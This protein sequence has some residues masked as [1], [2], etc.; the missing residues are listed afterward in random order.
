MQAQPG[1]Q[2]AAAAV[3]RS[4][5]GQVGRSLPIV[6]GFAAR[7]PASAV[8]DLAGGATIRRLTPDKSV[9]FSMMV[10]AADSTGATSSAG[11]SGGEDQVA[12]NYPKTTGATRVWAQG[13][14]GAGVT[15]AIIDTGVSSVPDLDGRI[16]AGPDFSGEHDS[17][18]DSYGH[19]TVMA[20]VIAGDGTSSANN[21]GGAYVGIA[22]EATVLSVKVAGRNGATDVSTVL[23]AMQ[24]IASHRA[25]HNIRVL[26]LSWGTTSQQSPEVDPINY[27]VQRLWRS[28]IVVVAAAGNAGPHPG[29]VTKPGDD[30]VIITAGA[31]ND[32]QNSVLADDTVT[33]WSSRGPTAAGAAKPDI[34]APGRTLVATR[35]P[36]SD[37][38]QNNPQALVGSSYIRGSGTSQATAAVSGSVAL[39]IGRR[40]DLQP[41][42]VKYAV[43]STAVPIVGSSADGHGRIWLP[44]MVQRDV[45]AAPVQQSTASG[46]GSIEDSRGG[47]H[48]E[49]VCAGDSA[50]TRIQGEIDALCQPWNG[51]TW[52]G[53]TWTG[54]T[55][56]QNTW[57]GDTWSGDTWTGDT[58]S[59]D[60][61]T[62]DT[63]TGTEFLTAFWGNQ[64][65]WWQRLPGEPRAARTAQSPPEPRAHASPGTDK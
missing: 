58:W 6:D 10:G 26:N 1:Q 43:T 25:Q 7:V 64:T 39:L 11:S 38:E 53:D 19:G 29:T 32:R 17:L 12:S 4:A 23:A 27:A 20:G 50:P 56:S 49:T 21:P 5:G 16:I 3:V 41:D 30:P 62:G 34:V 60:T 18:Q 47:R 31:Y 63:W 42:Q 8:H 52:T 61:W 57:S 22:P 65:P 46:L 36:G 28:G 45:A 44:K 9:R 55:W 24:W 48:V 37:I 33:A 35:S 51:D 54:E 15:V 40:P 59:G 2:A 14:R 13:E